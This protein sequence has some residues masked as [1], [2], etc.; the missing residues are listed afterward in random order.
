MEDKTEKGTKTA[1]KT[2]LESIT[3]CQTIAYGTIEMTLIVV[4][5]YC[6]LDKQ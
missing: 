5:H 3:E 1:R 4:Y 2:P 6:L